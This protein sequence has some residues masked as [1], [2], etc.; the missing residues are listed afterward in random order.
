MNFCLYLCIFALV[1]AQNETIATQNVTVPY[2]IETV[3][4]QNVTVAAQNE[5]NHSHE[6][7]KA[8]QTSYTYLFVGC[9][10]FILWLV[11]DL[12]VIMSDQ[13]TV[14]RPYYLEPLDRLKREEKE[15]QDKEKDLAKKAKSDGYSKI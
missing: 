3:A 10:A 2:Q 11:I 12:W 4:T 15:K 8:S 13:K 9:G 7:T 1:A 5:H 14:N 6:P